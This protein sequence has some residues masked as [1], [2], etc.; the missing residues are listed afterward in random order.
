MSV[1]AALGIDVGTTEVKAG[2][3]GLDGQLLAL[4][5]HRH[6]SDVDPAAG[7]AEQDPETWWAGLVATVR[8]VVAATDAEIVALA[9]DGHGPT[10]TPVDAAGLPVHPAIT[11]QD[12]R[13][14][15]DA[16][17]LTD[18]TGRRGWALGVLPAAR[19]LERNAPAAAERTRWYLNS[20]EALAL[21]LTG[22]AR[23]SL[24]GAA[25][26]IEAEVLAR[27]RLAVKRLA[28]P[29]PAGEVLGP[30][31]REVAAELG[32]AAGTPVV[33]GVVDAYASLHG[34]RMLDFGDAIDVGGA[35]GGFGLYWDGPLDAAGS[36]SA[37]A[38]L[39][40]RWLVGGAMAATGAALD[41]WRD[42]I[43]GG[44]LPTPE[45]IAEAAAVHAGADGLVFLPY[46][47]GERSP[48]WDPGARGAFVGL[49]LQHGRA[50][51]TRAILE[52]SAYAVRHVAAGVL[53]AGGRV[54]AM[55][56]C[57]GPARSDAWN[58]LKADVTGFAVEV[59]RVLE[60]AVVG[61]AIVA[62]TGVGAQPDLPTA[63]R[64][65]ATIDHRLEPDP[66]LAAIYR[67]R[68]EEYLGLY[69]AIAAVLGRRPAML[70]SVP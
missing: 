27:A 57:G 42:G 12:T 14:A 39:H 43:L 53:S 10:L 40:G 16:T 15:S 32:L 24:V 58:Q 30:L 62:A 69:P 29:M 9:V 64:T 21:R 66:A 48:I 4:A 41:W 3:V 50:A 25:T 28:P 59:P 35:A 52:A 11:W 20:W 45:L 37:P 51:M 55:R 31:R 18:R 36:F 2:L 8:E 65:M 5:R 6:G 19:W 61:S 34:A 23:S 60:T 7:R 46:L 54:T 26:P 67:R 44:R 47:A 70:E 17:Y 22:R 1:T 33:A 56:V 49:T 68:F 63:I 13:S 38:P